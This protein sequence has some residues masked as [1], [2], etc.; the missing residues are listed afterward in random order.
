[1]ASI[2]CCLRWYNS[3]S[4]QLL[5]LW[6]L[7][8]TG[9]W[10]LQKSGLLL[11]PEAGIC[12]HYLETLSFRTH[13]P[14]QT[15]TVFNSQARLDWRSSSVNLAMCSLNSSAGLGIPKRSRQ[16][17]FWKMTLATSA[18]FPELQ[19]R[20]ANWSKPFDPNVMRILMVNTVLYCPAT[21]E[22]FHTI[23]K[24]W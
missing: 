5:C 22:S 19:H 13:K 16:S 8:A 4:S 2:P 11:G 1:M 14:K 10:C 17:V 6:K 9:C 23:Q 7:A 24:Q 21:C 18:R 12:Q 3:G 15:W 20:Q